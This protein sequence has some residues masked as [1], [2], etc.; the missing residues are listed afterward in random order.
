[1]LVQPT[2]SMFKRIIVNSIFDRR[3]SRL[4]S[5]NYAT[6]ENFH[7]YQHDQKHSKKKHRENLAEFKLRRIIL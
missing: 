2:H 4:K 1:M 3:W 7:K 5:F 6:G